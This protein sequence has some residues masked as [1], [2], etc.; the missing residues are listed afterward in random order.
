MQ[1]YGVLRKKKIF[2]LLLRNDKRKRACAGKNQH[3]TINTYLF[4]ILDIFTQFSC[5]SEF[6]NPS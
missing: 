1:N 6:I 3:T 5:I 2:R 4:S